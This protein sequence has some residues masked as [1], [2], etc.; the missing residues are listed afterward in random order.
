[1]RTRCELRSPWMAPSRSLRWVGS[2]SYY[3]GSSVGVSFRPP[4]LHMRLISLQFRKLVRFGKMPLV[5]IGLAATGASRNR[6]GIT[7]HLG[8]PDIIAVFGFVPPI[9]RSRAQNR[10][11][12]APVTSR[13]LGRRGCIAQS[14]SWY[15]IVLQNQVLHHDHALP[16][17]SSNRPANGEAV[18]PPLCGSPHPLIRP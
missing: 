15:H 4:I 14:S 12:V 18:W 11:A 13:A 8:H 16:V 5:E 3:D 17:S 9:R 1:M 6:E 10:D 7:S 2:D